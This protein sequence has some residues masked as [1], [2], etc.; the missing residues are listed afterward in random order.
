[1]NKYK[2]YYLYLRKIGSKNYYSKLST[3]KQTFFVKRLSFLIKSNMGMIES[4][5][6]I[7]NQAKSKT[8]INIYHKIANDIKNGKSLAASM[9]KYHGVFGT[10]A[11]NLIK[12]GE[13]SG[14]LNENLNYLALELKKKE[15]LRK[16]II[17]SFVYPFIITIATLGIT[18]FLVGYIFPKI[19]PIFSSMR[20]N[21]PLSTRIIIGLTNILKD[22]GLYISIFLF[23]IIIFFN[24]L[25]K[26]NKRI[27]LI[28]N[29]FVLKIPLFG[30]LI[31]N[32]N[33]ANIC[34][35]TGILL[36]NNI[37]VIETL[38]ITQDTVDNI[39]YKKSFSNIINGVSTGKT[40]SELINSYPKLFPLIVGHM[41]AVGEKSGNLSE[42]FIYLSEFYE[43]EFDDLTKNL[44]S[45]LEP[46]LMIIMGVIVGF[47]AISVITPIYEITTSI[48]K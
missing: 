4:I 2:K 40:I 9:E 35:T 27:N 37:S 36:K 24:V 26:K 38:R 6:L 42:S 19:I 16:K 41:V 8:E 33:L 11:I 31:K 15:I 18:G 32:Y 12:A 48:N 46:L 1:M 44:S 7:K 25:I 45:S 34:R 39:Y 29:I 47:V 20:I 17:G 10:F 30:T 22:Y 14:T 43:N 3:K 5:N 21:L 13:S 23:L 28:F